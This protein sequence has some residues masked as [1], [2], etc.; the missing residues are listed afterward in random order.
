MNDRV[1]VRIAFLIICTIIVIAGFVVYLFQEYKPTQPETPELA[2]VYD[3]PADQ[4]ETTVLVETIAYCPTC[5]EPAQGY[6]G[7]VVC[8]NENCQ[9][10]GIAVSVGI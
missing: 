8:R 4:D 1:K 7:V 3:T 5:G 2:T 6:D 9:M 10:Y